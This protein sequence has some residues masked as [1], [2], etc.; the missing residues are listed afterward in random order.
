MMIFPF[1]KIVPSVPLASHVYM[2]IDDENTMYYSF[3]FHPERPLTDEDLA[4]EKEWRGIHTENIPG[5]D[6]A[7]QNKT[8]DY[9]IDRKLQASGSDFSP[10]GDGKS[11]TGIY[12]LCV[13]DCGIQESMGPI[14]DR[15]LEHLLPGDMSIVRIRRLL[16]QVL[17]EHAAG[18]PLPAIDPKEYRVRAARFEA[19]KN[20]VFAEIASEKC[21]DIKLSIPA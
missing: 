16:L 7:V 8:N 6:Y 1:H 5:T 17:K 13:Q 12:G 9:L 4:R 21:L 20:A 15:T 3:N 18:K 14:A 10:G 2:P 19:P 11:F